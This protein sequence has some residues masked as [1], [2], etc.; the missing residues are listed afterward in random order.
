MNKEKNKNNEYPTIYQI[1]NYEKGSIGF[2]KN[3]YTEVWAKYTSYSK[4]DEKLYE[5]FSKEYDK[6]FMI[7]ARVCLLDWMYGTRINSTR[8]IIKI[9]KKFENNF[10]PNSVKEMLGEVAKIKK[11]GDKNIRNET[12]FFSK[13]CHWYNEVNNETP[14]PIYDQNVRVGLWIYEGDD[15]SG[16]T[17]K[18]S[19]KEKQ[20]I[21]YADGAKGFLE[22]MNFFITKQLELEGVD[23]V[24]IKL[25]D[26]L[27]TEVSIHRLVDKFLW[28]MYKINRDLRSAEGEMIRVIKNW[29]ALK[30]KLKQSL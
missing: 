4:N 7:D 14:L 12:S 17:K 27:K 19:F 28:L 30:E 22:R 20:N 5:I 26:G 9:I 2:L 6:D 16:K 8:N 15:G 21:N 29:K 3:F 23:R 24:A 1:K 10:N 18:R 25:S 13:Y 11:K